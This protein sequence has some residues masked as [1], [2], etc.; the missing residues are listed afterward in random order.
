MHSPSKTDKLIAQEEGKLADS[1]EHDGLSQ[2]IWDDIVKR[3]AFLY[4][5]LIFLNGSVMW[6]YYSCLSA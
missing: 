6:A 5:A 2:E 4:Y 3:E 1:L